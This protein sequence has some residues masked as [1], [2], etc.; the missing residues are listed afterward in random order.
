L[1]LVGASLQGGRQELWAGEWGA[2]TQLR[3][4]VWTGRKAG[5]WKN[6]ADLMTAALAGGGEVHQ[7][8]DRIGF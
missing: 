1:F 8:E 6:R 3:V 7:A 2:D 5:L 4:E